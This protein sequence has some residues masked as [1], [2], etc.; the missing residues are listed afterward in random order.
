MV[1]RVQAARRVTCDRVRRAVRPVNLR[2]A[3]DRHVKIVQTR[4]YC[5]LVKLL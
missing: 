4:Q 3:N 1:V 2:P 5:P